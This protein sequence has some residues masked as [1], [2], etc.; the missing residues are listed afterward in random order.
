MFDLEKIYSID[1]LQMTGYAEQMRSQA[2]SNIE[3]MGSRRSFQGN[4]Q[5]ENELVNK[6]ERELVANFIANNDEE[7]IIANYQKVGMYLT[8]PELKRNFNNAV[9]QIINMQNQNVNQSNF[10]R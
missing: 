3:L 5:I 4:T 9:Q 10:H 2:P 1:K 7:Y 6:V 8:T